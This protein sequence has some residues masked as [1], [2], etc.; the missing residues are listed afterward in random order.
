MKT[1]NSGTSPGLQQLRADLA[2]SFAPFP[3]EALLHLRGNLHRLTPGVYQDGRGGGCLFYILSETLP[4]QDRIASLDRFTR[5]FTGGTT[6]AHRRMPAYQPPKFV[7]RI[8]DS[9][10]TPDVRQRYPGITRLDK[11]VLKEALDAAIARGSGSACSRATRQMSPS[12]VARPTTTQ[13]EEPRERKYMRT[14]PNLNNSTA[15]RSFPASLAPGE[16]QVWAD[17]QF[18]FKRFPMDSLLHLRRNQHRLIRR[19]FADPRGGGCIFYLLTEHMSERDRIDCREKLTR[20]FTGGNGDPYREMA[21]YQPA[22]H[23]VYLWDGTPRDDTPS[24]YPGVRQLE[25]GLL[26]AALDAAIDQRMKQESRSRTERR[27][28][29]DAL[30]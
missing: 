30:A 11:A 19:V 13:N 20:Y 22:R 12:V 8:F 3:L 9:R 26:K 21:V 5:F 16:Q 7:T 1:R 10:L 24:R 2:A 25:I 4:E 27:V 18:V 15:L 6:E 28:P 14:T 17:L 29:E 23:L